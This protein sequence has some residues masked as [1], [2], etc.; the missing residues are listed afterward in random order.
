MNLTEE[1]EVVIWPQ[2]HYVFVERIGPFM[3]T[4][5]QAWEELHAMKPLIAEANSI[6]GA[7]ALYRMK[8]DTYRAGFILAAAPSGLPREISYEN[9]AGGKYRRFV[10]TGSY[11][12]LPQAT[13][14]VWEIASKTGLERRMD[15][16]I[17]HYPNNPSTTPEDKLITE[18][19]IPTA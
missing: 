3:Q 16:T 2:T 18:I 7:M 15:F 9:L 10:L 13:R 14:R 4:A 12:N 6:D 8:P 1:P 17:E 19:L 5:R 11:A